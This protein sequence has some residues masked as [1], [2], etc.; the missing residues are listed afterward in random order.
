MLTQLQLKNFKGWRDTQP[1]KLKPL[2]ILFGT[3]SSGKSSLE[4]FL[5]MLKQT[6]ESSDRKTVLFPGDKDSVVNLGSFDEFI[7]RR[8]PQLKLEFSFGWDL[9]SPLSVTNP[10][11]NSKVVG[12]QMSF[13]ATIG[14]GGE[15]PNAILVDRFS[16]TLGTNQ[17]ENLQVVLERK[18]SAKL[19]YKVE[20]T[21]YDL[22]RKQMKAWPLGAP[23]KFYGFPDEV[24]IYYQNADI[25]QD[26]SLELERLLRSISYLGPLRS[27][28]ERL[29][30]WTGAEPE[31]VGFAG[32]QT[33]AAI[34]SAKDRQINYRPKQRTRTFQ[35]VI[36]E[37]LK[38]LGVIDAFRIQ[39]IVEGQKPYEVKV[40][41]TAASDWV[42][43][44]DVGFGVSQV[45]PVLTQCFYAPA[46]SILLIEQ[47]EIHLH[48]KAQSNLADVLIDALNSR[49]KGLP[50]N[51]QLIVETHS[52]H[53]LNRLQRRIAERSPE[54]L[55]SQDRVAAYFAETRGPESRL[56]PLEMD[57][58]GNITNWPENFFGDTMG[59]LMA[60][61]R[62]VADRQVHAVNDLPNP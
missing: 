14:K 54:H 26:L 3:N 4:Q 38:N 33:V 32:E 27:R 28:A 43:L 41:T 44:P 34:L 16:Y 39:P 29:Y 55:I 15:K 17:Q 45:L 20:A 46:G 40:K 42:D 48:P 8:N 62:A 10:R 9:R 30:T 11:D 35:Y 31:S 25:V 2:T 53:F 57:V 58:D 18:Q 37:Q 21:G 5:L 36:A 12:D 13:S 49:E 47:P 51:L 19:E 22:V 23:N 24:P 7:Y 59:D 56:T 61:Q 50:R 6:V 60:M 1:V 52:E